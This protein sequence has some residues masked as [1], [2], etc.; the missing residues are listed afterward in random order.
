[1]DFDEEND[2]IVERKFQYVQDQNYFDNP[3]G[4]ESL[5]TAEFSENSNWVD[6]KL[7]KFN[8]VGEYRIYRRIKDRPSTDPNFANYSYYSGTPEIRIYAHRKPI[9]SATLDWDYDNSKNTYKTRWVCTSY[10]LDHQFSRADKGIVERKIMFRK[11]GGDWYYYIPDELEPG[12]YELRYY[13]K[14]VEG[15]WSDP[16]TMNFTLASS[17]PIQFDA[18]LRTLDPDFSLN[19]IPASEYL[20]VYDVWTRYPYNVKL[21]MALYSGS[22]RKTPL[23]TVTY[24]SSR[25]TK[26]GNDIHWGNINYEIPDTL[27]DGTYTFKITAVDASNSSKRVEKS[28]TV[29]VFTPI[30]LNPIM[31]ETVSTE[32]TETIKATT[33]KYADTTRAIMFYGTSYQ[34]T[35]NL[36]GSVSGKIKNWQNNTTISASIPEGTYTVRFT[37]TTP[38]GKSE[39][40][41]VTIRVE[42]L[43]ITEVTIEGG[44]NHWR[45]QKDIFDKQ[46]TN[47]PHRF[48]SLEEVTIRVK[49]TGYADKIEIRFSP[50]LEAK[51]YT[52]AHGNVYD[53]KADFDI[54]YTTFPKV[55]NIDNTI[56]D[57]TTEWKYILPLAKDTKT[58]DD[59][60]LRTPYRMIVKA[61]KGTVSREAVID[62]IDITGSIYDLIDMQPK[63]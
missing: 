57:N 48:L 47:E 15:V 42:A 25:D 63:N 13:V 23:K 17:P 8:K 41:N 4:M 18:N 7:T 50:E 3:T 20:E 14:D 28:F 53:M 21:E 5:A 54:D 12:T 59:V 44:W 36:T 24:N 22:T 62:D 32:S 1:M 61:W 30:N 11:T 60:R 16:Y 39:T 45:G 26:T 37:A 19:S 6:T 2:P 31:P 43:K 9:A 38:S 56:K 40:K 34:K 55:I 29:K 35:V 33:S 51:T 46:L 10:D 58:W 49:T 27:S 52:D